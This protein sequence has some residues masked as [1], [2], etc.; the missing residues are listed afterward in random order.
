MGSTNRQGYK[1]KLSNKQEDVNQ[2]DYHFLM[3]KKRGSNWL[4]VEGKVV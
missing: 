3:T 4:V 2:Q 1:H